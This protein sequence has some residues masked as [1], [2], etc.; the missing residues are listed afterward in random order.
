[1]YR[2]QK[3][4]HRFDYRVVTVVHAVKLWPEI[5]TMVLIHRLIA[6]WFIFQPQYTD[7]PQ[8][9]Y[10]GVFTNALQCCCKNFCTSRYILP[11]HYSPAQWTLSI[12]QVVFFFAAWQAAYIRAAA[13]NTTNYWTKYIQCSRASQ[14]TFTNLHWELP[15]LDNSVKYISIAVLSEKEVI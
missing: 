3:K 9:V 12:N 10:E 7:N 8:N 4:L 1:M 13:S 11:L 5:F 2:L 6:L 15:E 14:P